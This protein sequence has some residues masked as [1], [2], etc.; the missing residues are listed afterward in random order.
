MS[1]IVDEYFEDME[2]WAEHFS[3]AIDENPCWNLKNCAIEPLRHV[4]VTPAEVIVTVDLPYANK[5]TA[6]VKVVDENALEIS[7]EMRKK[8]RLNELGV[9]HM[10]G[11]IQRFHSW[12]RIPV[13]VDVKRMKI[14]HK[15][16]ILE[17]KLPRKR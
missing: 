6:K 11:V 10:E 17:I 13:R 1:D 12:I 7:A 5:S 3:S 9:T 15:K 16:G 8:I 4:T 14:Q 2:R